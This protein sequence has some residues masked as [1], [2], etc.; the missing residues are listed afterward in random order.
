M[1][2]N[3]SGKKILV[4]DDEDCVA[5]MMRLMLSDAG[6]QTE[7]ARSGEDAVLLIKSALSAN[8]TF[9]I[10]IT[11]ICM[12]GISGIQLVE[13][14]RRDGLDVPVVA[15]SGAFDDEALTRLSRHGCSVF[16]SKPFERTTLLEAINVETGRSRI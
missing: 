3:G 14:L 13:E 2:Q 16:L 11:D 15:M 12:P 1:T 7:T 4:V 10:V 5:S 6:F 9:D 8:C